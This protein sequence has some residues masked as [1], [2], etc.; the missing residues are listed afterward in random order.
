MDIQVN[1]EIDILVH[2]VNLELLSINARSVK[3][4][5]LKAI[6]EDCQPK[7]LLAS[8]T[9]YGA[10][11]NECLVKMKFLLDADEHKRVVEMSGGGIPEHLRGNFAGFGL[12]GDA[13]VGADSHRKC[14]FMGKAVDL[15]VKFVEQKKLRLGWVVSFRAQQAEL[16]AKFGLAPST[17]LDRTAGARTETLV[18][19]HYTEVISETAFSDEVLNKAE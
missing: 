9:L 2:F 10:R 11:G 7:G 13:D 1:P 16:C 19:S 6:I 12:K 18:N 8:F 3:C 14:P 5:V 15:L 17:L 4:G